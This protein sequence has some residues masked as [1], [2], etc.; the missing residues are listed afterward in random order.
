MAYI[1]QADVWCDSCGERIKERIASENP[2]L[3]PED[4]DGRIYA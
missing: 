2:D 3:V 1:Y 4:A